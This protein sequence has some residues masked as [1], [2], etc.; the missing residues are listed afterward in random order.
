MGVITMKKLLILVLIG[1]PLLVF[2]SCSTPFAPDVEEF[3]DLETE[4]RN[5]VNA[6]NIPSLAAWVVKG[7]SIVW[8]QYYGYAD[9]ES[10]R[11]ADNNTIYGIASVSKLI[12][13]TAAMQLKEQ[14]LINLD[15]DINDYLPF[16]VRNPNF[17]ELKITIY[18]LLTHSSGLNWPEDESEVPGYYKEYPLDSAPLLGDWIPQFILPEGAHYVPA[19]WMNH[20]PGEREWY[21]NIG[22]CLLAYLVEVVSGTDYNE[23]CKQNIFEPLEMFNTSHAYADLDMSNMA[24][25]YY[26]PTQQIGFYRYQGYPAGDLKCTIEDFSH[27]I[28]AYMNGGQYKG[29]RILEDNTV[30]EILEIRNA[31]SGLCLIWNCTLGNWYGHAGGK[32]GTSAYVEYKRGSNV[33][34]M[35]VTNYRHPTVYPSNKTHALVRKI[36][37]RYY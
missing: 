1:F 11:D 32:T 2:Q 3:A 9:V 30:N 36:A 16:T 18:N 5:E 37:A 31:A 34:L 14:G 17:P 6:N 15:D 22:V 7:D 19:V 13:V 24:T 26:Q 29:T 27:F 23:Y 10:H 4:I 20:R 8:Q 33:A 25:L 28:I 12:V 35:I 21:S